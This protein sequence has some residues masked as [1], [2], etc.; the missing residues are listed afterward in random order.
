VNPDSESIEEL[1]L[2][3]TDLGRMRTVLEQAG[4]HV[5]PHVAHGQ[6]VHLIEPDA[7]DGVA[8]LVQQHPIA[9]WLEERMARTGEQLTI[10][11]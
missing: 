6:E 7:R 2:L 10:S 9:I 1:H 4:R 5:I 11:S 8:F 3:A